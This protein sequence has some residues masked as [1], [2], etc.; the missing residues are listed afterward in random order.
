MHIFPTPY[1]GLHPAFPLKPNYVPSNAS[2]VAASWP[3]VVFL[4]PIVGSTLLRRPVAWVWASKLTAYGF[5]VS[6]LYGSAT[7]RRHRQRAEVFLRE[8]NIEIPRGEWFT[9]VGH[10]DGDDGALLGMITGAAIAGSF[11]RPRSVGGWRRLAAALSVGALAG[12]CST[13]TREAVRF[14]MKDEA[15]NEV[16]QFQRQRVEARTWKAQVDLAWQRAHSRTMTPNVD[17]PP[18]IGPFSTR[19]VIDK[20]ESQLFKEL[21][22]RIAPSDKIGHDPA[23]WP[24]LS[25]EPHLTR[26]LPSV[27]DSEPT[28]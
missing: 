20:S 27:P 4:V 11:G 3:S 17:S 23:S 2:L 26:T 6:V 10:F 9:R 12:G 22:R 7:S 28:P 14:A 24:N 25:N 1:E 18:L 15:R 13:I 16:H 8:Q 19:S 21:P 5:V